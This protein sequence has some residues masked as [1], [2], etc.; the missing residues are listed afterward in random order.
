MQEP[1]AA[2]NADGKRSMDLLRELETALGC[3]IVEYKCSEYRMSRKPLV[4]VQNLIRFHAG[5][6][7][8]IDAR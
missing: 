6:V 5:C 4:E 3:R 1:L 2:S 7:S 8:P